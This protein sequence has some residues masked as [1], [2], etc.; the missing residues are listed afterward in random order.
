[1]E[2]VRHPL[3]YGLSACHL[4][5]FSSFQRRDPWEKS[6][7][8]DPVPGPNETCHVSCYEPVMLAFLRQPVSL[9]RSL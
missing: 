4:V 8:C 6:C 9:R 7:L 5:D 2:E 3:G 1:M